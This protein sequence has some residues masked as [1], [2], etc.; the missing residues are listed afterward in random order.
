MPTTSQ[1]EYMVYPRAIALAEIAWTPK[2]KLNYDD[3]VVRLRGNR[4]LLDL[5]QVNYAK[6][7]FEPTATDSV[8]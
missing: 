8:K 3:F 6:H 5:W 2:D 1:V 7:I 4:H